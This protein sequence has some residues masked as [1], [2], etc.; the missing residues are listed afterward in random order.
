[1]DWSLLK[2]EVQT[3]FHKIKVSFFHVLWDM[4]LEQGNLTMKTKATN[5]GLESCENREELILEMLTEKI[6]LQTK[7]GEVGLG[8][9]TW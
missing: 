9:L 4:C 8:I 3:P 5:V 2:I 1:L 7:M 6:G